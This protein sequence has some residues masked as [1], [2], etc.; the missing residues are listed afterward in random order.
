MCRLDAVENLMAMKDT[1]D[2]ARQLMRQVPD[3]ERL[4]SRY[5]PS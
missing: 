2:S 3:L 5:P 4:L 1:V